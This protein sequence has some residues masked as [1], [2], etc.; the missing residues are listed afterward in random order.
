MNIEQVREWAKQLVFVVGE[1]RKHLDDQDIDSGMIY[2]EL[3]D[4]QRIVD[5]VRVAVE[6]HLRA[7]NDPLVASADASPP[8]APKAV[9]EIPR[10]PQ[11]PEQEYDDDDFAF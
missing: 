9:A 10:A 6:G 2:M 5:E 4:V 7:V 11:E 8:P 3:E 1:L